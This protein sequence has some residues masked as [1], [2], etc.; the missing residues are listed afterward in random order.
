[1]TT[2]CRE[3][4]SVDHPRH[5]LAALPRRGFLISSWPWRSLAYLISTVPV[6]AGLGCGLSV[7]AL[8]WPATARHLADGRPVPGFTVLFILA[9]LA[10]AAA[11]GP[12]LSIGVAVL[13]RRRLG[14]VDPRP[15][16]SGHQLIAA[17]PARWLRVRLA[18]AATWRE[19]A[20]AAFL[21][22]F[23]PVVYVALALLLVMDVA[24]VVSPWL[25]GPDA[26]PISIGVAQVSSTRQA[27]PYAV[28]G[29]I[30]IPLWLYL[31][32]LVTAGQMAVAR[33]LLGS[34]GLNSPAV[35]EVTRSR[36]RLVDAYEAERRRIERDLHD[37]AQHRLTSLT[38]QLGMARLD[39]PE[40]SPAAA[41]LARAH[42][43][44]KDLMVVLRN[45]VHG[46]H[47]QALTDLGLL[48]AVQE[49]ATQLP[50]PVTVT[51]NPPWPGRLA[52]RIESTAYLVASEAL[53]NVVKHSHASKAEVS[54]TRTGN[55]LIMQIRDDGSGSADPARGTGLTGLADR[56]AAAGGRLLLASPVGGPTLIRV[57]LPCHHL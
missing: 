27:L 52:E 38:L 43:Q 20:Y 4:L 28:L 54:I 32:G 17:G 41:A 16:V 13:E 33:A 55:L 6:A 25:A 22:T 36:A 44:A 31:V 34:G 45:I 23:V 50:I 15:V 49:L 47:P 40:D 30:F 21:V 56:A 5:L 37:I 18:E 26:G 24:L 51:A 57:E 46:I 12:P 19:V 29:A 10:L 39:M 1:M 42:E 48:G 7:V 3:A 9:G 8:P 53:T 11:I 14:I 35:Q 2:G